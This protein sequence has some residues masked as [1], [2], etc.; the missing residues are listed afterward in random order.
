MVNARLFPVALDLRERRCIVIARANQ[1]EAAEKVAALE[2]CR[3]RVTRIEETQVSETVLDGAFFVLSTIKDE[4]LSKRLRAYAQQYRFLLWCVDQPEYGFVAMMA[5]AGA[6]DVRIGITTSGTAP[7]VAKALRIGLERA[8]DATFTRFCAQL[9]TL[10]K[11]LRVRMPASGHAQQRVDAMRNA[12]SGFEVQIAFRYPPWF[13]DQSDA[14]A[15]ERRP[16][17]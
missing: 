5:Q 9:G 7:S 13:R 16:P 2:E 1:A 12:T 17:H 15:L 8:M 6:G 14:A 11:E 10:R 3:A 4:A